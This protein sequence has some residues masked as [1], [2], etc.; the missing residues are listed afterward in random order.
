[1]RA[2]RWGAASRAGEGSRSLP[3]AWCRGELLPRAFARDLSSKKLNYL[4]ESSEPSVVVPT[5]QQILEELNAGR[6][7]AGNVVRGKACEEQDLSDWIQSGFHLQSQ[8]ASLS[9]QSFES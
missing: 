1:M 9:R 3:G 6:E 4:R 8:R 2:V 5:V 7:M